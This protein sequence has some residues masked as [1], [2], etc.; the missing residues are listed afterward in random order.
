MILFSTGIFIR[1]KCQVSLVV[2]YIKSETEQI[3]V[4]ATANCEFAKPLS[5]KKFAYVDANNDKVEEITASLKVMRK[6][7][8]CFFD[9][10]EANTLKLV[11]LQPRRKRQLQTTISIC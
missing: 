7:I 1:T 5:D 9:I 6:K 10:F 4:S 2:N 8:N 11:Q 3:Q